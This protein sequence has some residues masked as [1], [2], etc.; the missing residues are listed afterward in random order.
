MN[1]IYKLVTI[2]SVIFPAAFVGAQSSPAAPA[3]SVFKVWT[4]PNGHPS[5]FQNDLHAASASSKSDIWAVGQTAIHF[6]G[7][8]WTA[9]SVPEINGDNTSRLGGVV[10]FA[11][12]N[13]WT[14]GITGITLGNTNQVIEH[15]DGTAWSI[16]TGP[17]FLPNDEPALES[18]S[19]ISPSDMWAAGFILTDNFS[20][21]FPLF[22]HY[23]GSSWTAF[24]TLFSDASM[25]GVSADATNDVW[26]VGTVAEFTTYAEHYDGNSWS[27]VSTP[28]AGNG[29]NILFGVAA[30]SPA[31]VWAAGYYTQDVNS[32]RPTLT[33]IEHWDGTSWKI[34]PSPNVGPSSQYQ[35]N[36][37][38]G[39][40]AISKND[41]WAFGSYFAA[42][43]SGQQS[44]LVE[45]WNGKNWK[46]VPSP[47]PVTGSFRNDILFGG[48]VIPKG[49]LWLV[50]NEFGSTLAINATGQ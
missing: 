22:E 33:L 5:P 47:D 17:S 23:D 18:I 37:L 41:V 36:E 6:D 42:D 3:S 28:N 21:L 15:F 12:N 25:F 10:D 50:G 29:W 19:A 46:I 38:W 20:Q 30:L 7:R 45:H 49:D 2:L 14:V 44:T 48:T 39:I 27:V 32:T 11:P 8:K 43:G 34:V 26:S 35:S 16:A 4:T 40:T 31:D 24:E 9:F 13:V 1:R